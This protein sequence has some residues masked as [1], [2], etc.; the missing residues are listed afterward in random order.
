MTYL[1][2]DLR[3]LSPPF[4]NL[5]LMLLFSQDKPWPQ[6]HVILAFY[7]LAHHLFLLFLVTLIL[8]FLFIS[9]KL[10]LSPTMQPIRLRVGDFSLP[11]T[12]S[13]LASLIFPPSLFWMVFSI[14]IIASPWYR[15][16]W[17]ALK[18]F[19]CSFYGTLRD[20]PTLIILCTIQ[21]PAPPQVEIEVEL[22]EIQ[23]TGQSNV[24]NP[25]I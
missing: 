24:E 19:L 9:V 20:I 7:I 1:L 13:M 2:L 23:G 17:N 6:D 12:L 22:V 15:L 21:E 16:L 14:V 4:I 3:S 18:S 8:L 5:T 10:P 25:F 11:L